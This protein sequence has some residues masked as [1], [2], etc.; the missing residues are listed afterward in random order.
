MKEYIYAISTHTEIIT[1]Q[2]QSQTNIYQYNSMILGMSNVMYEQKSSSWDAKN[3]RNVDQ[4]EKLMIRK[5][6]YISIPMN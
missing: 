1:F 5:L 6:P 3:L 4:I 2:I